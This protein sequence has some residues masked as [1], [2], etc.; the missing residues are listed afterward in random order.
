[1]IELG[2]ESITVLLTSQ[3]HIQET[4]AKYIKFRIMSIKKKKKNNYLDF[5]TSHADV[6]GW[7][8]KNTNI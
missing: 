1:M 3:C 2:F 6:L 5:L 4:W 7:K 8:H